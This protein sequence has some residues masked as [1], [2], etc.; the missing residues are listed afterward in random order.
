MV[1]SVFLELQKRL[2]AAASSADALI[3]TAEADEWVDRIQFVKQLYLSKKL[4]INLLNVLLS[5]TSHFKW[6]HFACPA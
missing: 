4:Q 1:K 2:G 3:Q 6:T 5:F